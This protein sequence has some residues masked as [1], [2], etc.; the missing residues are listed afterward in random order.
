MNMSEL[1]QLAREAIMEMIRKR[2]DEEFVP[3]LSPIMQH[4]PTSTD[5]KL[6]YYGEENLNVI[7]TRNFMF[8]L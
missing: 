6:K 8:E 1:R 5:D 7:C 2:L 4:G 3:H